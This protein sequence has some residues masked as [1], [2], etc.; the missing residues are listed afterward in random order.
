MLAALFLDNVVLLVY[1]HT[2]YSCTT[3]TAV[4]HEGGP[5]TTAAIRTPVSV[6]Y[7]SVVT[8][9]LKLSRV[10]RGVESDTAH[11]MRGERE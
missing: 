10:G 3:T 8:Y 5:N 1:Q 9:I 2:Y 6:V 11:E 7:Y 4:V